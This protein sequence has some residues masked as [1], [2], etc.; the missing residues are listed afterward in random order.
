M[1]VL[2]IRISTPMAALDGWID[3]ALFAAS[4]DELLG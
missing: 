1:Y 3:R 2:V 4:V